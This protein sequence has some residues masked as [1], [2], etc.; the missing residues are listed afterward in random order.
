MTLRNSMAAA[1]GL[2]ALFLVEARSGPAEK[3]ASVKAPV[4]ALE[5]ARVIDGLGNPAV[6]SQTLV[7]SGGKILALGADGSVAVPADA[8]IID[9]TH[10]SVLPGYVM[11][12]E[13]LYYSSI[14][15]T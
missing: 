11:V 9:L 3:F 5:H 10:K 14:Y 15:G 4:V 1:A 2:T 12:H 13:H 7:I 6:V 8:L